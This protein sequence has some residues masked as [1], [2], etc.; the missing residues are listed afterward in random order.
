MINMFSSD[1]E[2]FLVN[3]YGCFASSGEINKCLMLHSQ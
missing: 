1:G 2:M 3:Y